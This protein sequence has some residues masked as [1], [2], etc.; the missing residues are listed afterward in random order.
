MRWARRVFGLLALTAVLWIGAAEA[1]RQGAS[2]ALMQSTT[3][4]GG[5]AEAILRTEPTALFPRRLQGAVARA[6]WPLHGISV[7]GVAW[8]AL[9]PLPRI[10][11][12]TALQSVSVAHPSGEVRLHPDEIGVDWHLTHGLALT[13][14]AL[15]GAGWRIA[16]PLGAETQVERLTAR[17]H[18]DA[19]ARYA[20]TLNIDSAHLNSVLRDQLDPAEQ[21]PESLGPLNVTATL[22]FDRPL[23]ALGGAPRLT[24]LDLTEAQLRWGGLKLQAEARLRFDAAGRGSGDIELALT[25]WQEVLALLQEAGVI[26]EQLARQMQLPLGLAARRST[27]EALRVKLTARDGVI[28]F[29]PLPITGL[30]LPVGG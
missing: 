30:T 9:S 24:G 1:L 22:D 4:Q 28:F 2:R 20:A 27:T 26:T 23:T 19:A 8:Q 17:L 13:S 11:A 14:F 18:H 6:S 21:L 12:L 15:D 5:M 3:V 16:L 25:G 10:G 29:G 7:E